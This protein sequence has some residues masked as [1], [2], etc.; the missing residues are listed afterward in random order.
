MTKSNSHKV[1]IIGVGYTPS[2]PL[3]PSR[4]YKEMVFDAAV[5]AYCDAGIEF[6]EIQSFVSCSEDFLEGTSIF[7]EYT[8]DQLGAAL[9]PVHTISADGI[10]GVAAAYMQILTGRFDIIAVEAHSKASNIV[11]IE[12]IDSLALD[13]IYNRPLGLNP[14]FILGL[15]MARFCHE[16][17]T[18]PEDCARVVVKNRRNALDHPFAPFA[19]NLSIKD[20]ARSPVISEPLR[21]LD[22]AR[23]S[24]G[25][26]VVV[27]SSASA[28]KKM[29]KYPVWITGVGWSSDAPSLETREWGRPLYAELA[30][31]MAFKMAGMKNPRKA[32]D[33]LEIDDTAS[34][35]ELQHLEA[36]GMCR[37]G[38]AKTLLRRGETQ[39]DG[40]MPVNPSGG[41]LGLGHLLEATGLY[42]VAEACEQLRGFAGRRQ[43]KGAKSGL[44]MS[45]RGIP[46]TSGAVAVLEI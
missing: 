25:A 46:A 5:R 9:K 14:H 7:D 6:S 27:L 42:R 19:S 33:F 36:L 22:V 35:K 28:A 24:D 32:I 1:G 38:E 45:W 31:A 8:P 3:S 13:P 17:K 21:E 29:K 4:S 44:V 16:T 37:R 26:C 18:S 20:V 34:Y 15:E 40:S 30:G 10:F 43:V 41:S 23:H 12:E 39:R 11:D 2:T